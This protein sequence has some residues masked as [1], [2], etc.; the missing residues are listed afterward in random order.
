MRIVRQLLGR[1]TGRGPPTDPACRQGWPH[2][3]TRRSVSSC[4]SSFTRRHVGAWPPSRLR[5]PARLDFTRTGSAVDLAATRPFPVLRDLQASSSQQC[6]ED[7]EQQPG[8]QQPYPPRHRLVLASG[9]RARPTFLCLPSARKD[10]CPAGELAGV[11]VRS[12]SRKPPVAD[13]AGIVSWISR[14]GG[15]ERGRSSRRQYSARG[16]ERCGRRAPL[17]RDQLADRDLVE[18]AVLLPLGDQARWYLGQRYGSPG[19]DFDPVKRQQQHL[20]ALFDQLF[21]SSTFSDPGR[22]DSALLTATSAVGVDDSLG[23]RQPGVA[24]LLIAGRHPGER[25]LLHR[26]GARHRDGGAGERRLPR[27]G[28]RDRMWQ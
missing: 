7:R 6:D 27:H 16:R 1:R 22:L 11:A 5:G 20:Q 3:R 23:K 2:A 28:G 10:S 8:H 9:P 4:S 24:G 14:R 19:G 17:L 13:P 15:P 25:R 26:P 12:A 18:L 21:N